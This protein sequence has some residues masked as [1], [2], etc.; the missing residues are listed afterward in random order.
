MKVGYISS[1]GTTKGW[2]SSDMPATFSL[3]V[4]DLPALKDWE[5]GKTYDLEMTVKLVGMRQDSYDKTMNGT[6]EVKD[7]QEDTP[8]EDDSEDN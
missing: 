2:E 3:T 5:V 4:K 6:F 7:V 8:E 1:K